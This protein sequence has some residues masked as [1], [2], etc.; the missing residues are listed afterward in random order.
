MKIKLILISLFI[1]IFSPSAEDS[2]THPIIPV[3]RMIPQ[4][5]KR[6]VL[7]EQ[8]VKIDGLK[9]VM[10][11]GEVDGVNG[12][13]TKS[14]TDYL[15]RVGEVLK[16][17]N[18]KVVEFYSP[19][20]KEAI[21]AELKDANFVFYAGHGIGSSNAPSYKATGSDGG[22]LVLEQVWTSGSDVKDWGVKPGALVFFMGACFTAGNAGHDIGKI[23]SEEA[24]RRVS[25]YSEPYLNSG[26]KGYY[27][28]WSDYEIQQIVGKLFAGQTLGESYGDTKSMGTV[29]QISHPKSSGN[30]LWFRGD[31]KAKRFDFAFAGKPELK[32]TDLFGSSTTKTTT[33]TTDEPVN[34]VIDESKNMDLIRAV[35]DGDNTAAVNALNSGAD[36]NAKY[37]DWPALLLAVS[38][39]KTDVVRT[40]IKSK[41]NLNAEING[42]SALSLAEGNKFQDV[43]KLLKDAG[44]IKSR[45]M[46]TGKKPVPA[47]AP[48]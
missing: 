35:Y 15:K 10:L 21:K 24:K 47:P 48:Q 27:A 44:A 5:K 11:G 46:N 36:P 45:S 12:S 25:Q 4:V 29:T 33:T 18:V 3:G 19:T 1:C 41:A 7:P 37:K 13:G 23:N 32:L 40:L 2:Q 28:A 9:A 31:N 38:Y 30:N 22:M 26:F 42:W 20:S 43:A 8:T 39:H 16:A 17:R 14:Y 6:A 34:V